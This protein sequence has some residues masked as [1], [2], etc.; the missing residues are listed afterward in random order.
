MDLTTR[1]L[2]GATTFAVLAFVSF[3]YGRCA[4]DPDC[5]FRV[6]GHRF[7]GVVYNHPENGPT[8]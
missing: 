2:L 6:C 5:H 3:V 1:L 7:C 8:P 4:G